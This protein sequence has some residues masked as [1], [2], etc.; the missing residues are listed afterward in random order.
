ME[1]LKINRNNSG[2]DKLTMCILFNMIIIF[3]IIVLSIV[4]YELTKKVEP[5]PRYEQVSINIKTNAYFNGVD[6]AIKY[7]NQLKYIKKNIGLELDLK[8][9]LE[10]LNNQKD[11]LSY[12]QY[13]YRGFNHTY[14]YMDNNGYLVKS[15]KIII[16]DSLI[17]NCDKYEHDFYSRYI[18]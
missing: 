2:S 16:I 18:K 11:S 4:Y 8:Y 12:E 3:S 13:F 5:E 9:L 10:H 1:K 15:K 17:T 14:K 6:Y 7:L